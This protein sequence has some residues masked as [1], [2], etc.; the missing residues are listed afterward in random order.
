M[1]KAYSHEIETAF[2]Y[3]NIIA[4]D[5]PKTSNISSS[6]SLYDTKFLSYKIVKDL[7]FTNRYGPYVGGCEEEYRYTVPSLKQSGIFDFHTLIDTN[8]NILHVGDSVSLQTAHMFQEASMPQDRNVIRYSYRDFEA[9]SIIRTRDGGRI[10]GMRING[11]IRKNGRDWKK[12]DCA[13]TSGGGWRSS[14]VFEIRRL[15][16]HWYC[17]NP[18]T[19]R[20]KVMKGVCK[21]D[22][23][24]E[25]EPGEFLFPNATSFQSMNEKQKGLDVV[26]LQLAPGWVVNG[27]RPD[28]WNIIKQRLNESVTFVFDYLEPETIVIQNI[29]LNNNIEF[30]ALPNVVDANKFISK[31]IA[32]F[33]NDASND[34][35]RIIMMDLYTFSIEMLIENAMSKEVGLL[36]FKDGKNI[37]MQLQNASDYETLFDASLGVEPLLRNKFQCQ[38]SQSFC[39]KRPHVCSYEPNICKKRSTITEDGMHFCKNA[40]GRINAAQACLIRCR[41]DSAIDAN[42]TRLFECEWKCNRLLMSLKPID[43]ECKEAVDFSMKWNITD[44]LGLQN[45]TLEM[46]STKAI[47]NLV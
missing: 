27:F 8:L 36:S 39:T 24:I 1:E 17:V 31:Y 6:D 45:E 19:N 46:R 2:S 43:W 3:M 11:M 32:Q 44:R 30:T 40:A 12:E 4:V 25:S 10:A 28:D 41:I 14:D 47:T 22:G 34:R 13:P 26:V 9:T 38:N 20:R 15:N 42:L 23:S 37:Q 21:I 7:F 18:D 35:R 33:N 16:H 5:P 29:H